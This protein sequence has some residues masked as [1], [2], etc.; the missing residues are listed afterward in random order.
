VANDI[1]SY[2][3]ELQAALRS[4]GADPAL[5][6][7]ALFDAEEYLQAEMAVG[8]AVGRGTAVYEA[9]LAAAT[10][11]YGSPDEVAAA[12]VG[13]PVVSQLKPVIGQAAAIEPEPAAEPALTPSTEAEASAEASA[14]A[15]A[16][17]EATAEAPTTGEAPY[18]VETAAVREPPAV[19]AGTPP[20]NAPIPA[21]VQAGMAAA[22][23]VATVGIAARPSVWEEI[24]GVFADTAVWKSLL[25]M[26]ISLCTGIVYFTIVVTGVSTAG[27]MSVL[28]IGVPLFLLVLG[29][30]R[31]M[32]L[33]EG[34]VVELLLGTRMP[35][36]PRAEPPNAG[37]FQRLWFWVKDGRTW[38]SMAYMI[39]MLPLGIIYFTIAVTGLATGVALV[40]GPLWAWT[41]WV[42]EHTF[43]YEGVSH[44]WLFPAWGVPLAMILGVI[45][46]VVLMHVVK[47]IGRGHAAFAKA[48]LV[49]LS[50]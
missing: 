43:I 16:M 40:A 12:Y 29:I 39:L 26:I 32:S 4:A 36:R 17:A 10:Q 3:R 1:D 28:I 37:F 42:G 50:N 31:A 21:G 18:D 24:F 23:T 27:G 33:F 48:M 45:V 19:G 2:L 49:R 7:D 14:E 20:P 15:E 41:G 13:V 46:L 44:D 6:Q 22:G 47:W 5:V 30:V 8:G 35:R 9:R 34:R 25:Y 38:L 11:G